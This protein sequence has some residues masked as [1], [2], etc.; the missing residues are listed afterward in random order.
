MNLVLDVGNTN[1]K[2][3]IF[4]C[5]KMIHNISIDRFS[6]NFLENF[7]RNFPSIKN[8][9]V[10]NTS[11]EI[12]DLLLFC[13]K[14]KIKLITVN[15]KCNIPIEIKYDTPNTLGSDRIAL[16]VGS[17]MKYKG[18]KLVID[19]G[20]CFTYDLILGNSYIGGQITPGFRMRL[21]ALNNFTEKLPNLILKRPSNFIGRSTK[22]SILSGVYHGIL[23][24]IEG[25]IEKYKLRYPN[26]IVI[27]TGGG[28]NMF[29]KNI[30][31]I[32]FINPHLLME[33]LNHI[34]ASNE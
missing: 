2:L 30:K 23:A 11:S 21:L 10:S 17:Y 26:I 33:G 13:K 6:I 3:G 32:N 1:I 28:I 22:N 24:E 29:K 15:N 16:A 27:L 34:I 19:L 8:V 18:D 9:C 20:T 14:K 25:I 31:N 4:E 12:P 5:N 7:L